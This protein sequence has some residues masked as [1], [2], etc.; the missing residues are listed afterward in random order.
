MAHGVVSRRARSAAVLGMFLVLALAVGG[1]QPASGHQPEGSGGTT[2]NVTP[3]D[4]LPAVSVVSVEG[5]G[6]FPDASLNITTVEVAQCVEAFGSCGTRTV[7]D[8]PNSSFTGTITV[9]AC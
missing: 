5:A 9:P 8:A 1:W 7:F 6:F 3:S 4:D 2:V